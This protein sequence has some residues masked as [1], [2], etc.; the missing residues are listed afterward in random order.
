MQLEDALNTIMKANPKDIQAELERRGC[1]GELG[2]EIKFSPNKQPRF[3]RI[4][5]WAEGWGS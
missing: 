2:S 3:I 1:W 5:E 4:V